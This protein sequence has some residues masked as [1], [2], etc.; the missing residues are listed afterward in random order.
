MNRNIPYV[1][2]LFCVLC[3]LHIA[4]GNHA[5]RETSENAGPLNVVFILADDLGWGDIGCFGQFQ[6]ETPNLDRLAASGMRFT[7]HY[8][9]APVCAPARCVLMTGR[10][11]GHAEI[12]GNKQAS[13]IDPS[14][15][16][17]QV[18][19]S[20]K[21]ITFARVLQQQGYKTGAFG[22]WGL[23]PVRSS[24]AP[25]RQ[26]FDEFFGYNCQAVA[27]SYYPAYLW[28][29]SIRIPLNSS[30]IPGHG[31]QLSGDI[32]P[33]EWVGENYAP[34]RIM[35]EAIAFLR[36]SA[37]QPFFLY[38]PLIEPHVALHPPLSRLDDFP[39]EWD[40]DVYRGENGYVPTTRP[41]AAYAALVTD[42]D[43]Y[44]GRILDT[45]EELNLRDRTLV[46]FTS[47]N[48]A[49]HAGTV[50]SRLN[51]G[52]TDMTFFQSTRHL[53]GF[54]GSVYEGGIR[55]PMIASLPGRI[56]ASIVSDQ[57]TYFADWFP[58]ILEATGIPHSDYDIDGESFWPLLIGE[59]PNWKRKNPMVWVFPEYGGQVAIRSEQWKL[60]RQRLN[61]LRGPDQWE[62]YDLSQDESETENVAWKY[63]DF[64]Q[65]LS[66]RLRNEMDDNPIFPVVVPID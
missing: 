27:H 54:K 57:P 41:R 6:F 25:D 8:S 35:E 12:R 42:I 26:G 62:L 28:N 22:K 17:G 10:H 34:Y 9:G 55:V 23:G 33:E 44:V 40:P 13:A 19:L 51:V 30:P 59:Q 45:L 18:P 29:N 11:L 50:N 37:D 47:D 63:S 38:L 20:E 56:Q 43:R 7:Q 66:E 60:V 61:S 64:V 21:A 14:F 5:E 39:R 1:F 4:K 58:T 2:S 52:G 24:G 48:G 46:I 16:E 53:R 3:G 49:T 31:K 32:R 65:L 15:E 36:D